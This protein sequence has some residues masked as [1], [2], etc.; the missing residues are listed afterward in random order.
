MLESLGNKF[1]YKKLTEA[2]QKSR[3]ILGR[4]VGP[5][6]DFSLP[7]R[8]GR[9][10]TDETWEN[11]F[12]NPLMK[13]KIK[14]RCCFGELGHPAE[15][16]EIDME[17]AAICLAEEP[18]KGKDGKLYAVFD[19]LSTPN[20]K[21]LKSLC[22][23]GFIPGISSRGQ[24]DII[25]DELGE[26]YVDP[27]T[28]ECECFDVVILPGVESARLKYV[29][30][31]FQKTKKLKDVILESLDTAKDD[32]E[33]KVMMETLK[34]LNIV[35]EKIQEKEE[36]FEEEVKDETT[37]VTSEAVEEKEVEEDK[38]IDEPVQEAV[39]ETEDEIIVP[40][41]E[42]EETDEIEE[43]EPETEETTEEENVEDE[44]LEEEPTEEEKVEEEEFEE[45]EDERTDEEIFLEYLANNFDEDKI[46]KVCDILDIE[47]VDDE[48]DEE[49]SDEIDST[50]AEKADENIEAEE[51]EAKEEETDEPEAVDDGLEKLVD[52]LQEALRSK[53]ELENTVKELQNKLA[54]SDAKVNSVNEE[55]Q[56]YKNASARLSVLA[57][58][59]KDLKESVS[60]LE[61][62]LSEKDQIIKD[63]KVKITRL[64]ESRKESVRNSKSLNE[65]VSVKDNEI[66]KLTENLNNV[67]EEYEAKIKT[68]NEKFNEVKT[69]KNTEITTLT[70]NLNKATAL[71]ESYKKLANKAVNKYIE[72]KA[73][74]LGLTP[75]DIKRKLGESYKM[76]D[77]DQVCNDLKAYSLN[78]S[79]L[80]F[81]VNRKVGVRVHEASNS[82]IKT[83]QSRN[84]YLED[85][86]VDD[87]LIRLANIEF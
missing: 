85:D 59:T 25:T 56:K 54:V 6:A 16:T 48:D 2:E 87:S 39:E 51:D 13:E 20:G 30:E 36:Q 62:S 72:V 83:Q 29:N 80:P 31:G 67:S 60:K 44:I 41:E 73:D 37:E 43:T 32:N 17:K 4:L 55:C 3:G 53:A 78:V 19:I 22:D 76:E 10:Y 69:Q 26:E 61:E 8:N 79:K 57:K 52:S 64:V 46:L 35:S 14:N 49:S 18:K 28:Y 34:G 38:V 82:M 66:K 45:I 27:D 70:E 40:T 24:G 7:T 75:S 81:D 42:I 86:D 50:E 33:R 11:V 9:K 12:N 58:T 84:N 21:I 47:V 15:R 1:E 63:Q 65:N 23:Y 5:C 74:M 71:K 77:V 68:L